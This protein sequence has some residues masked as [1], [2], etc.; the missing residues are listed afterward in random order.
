VVAVFLRDP[1][2]SLC[3]RLVLPSIAD[4]PAVSSLPVSEAQPSIHS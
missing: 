4:A 3:H 2:R 1:F